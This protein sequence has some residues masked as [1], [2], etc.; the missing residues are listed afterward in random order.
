MDLG[1]KDKIALV[2]GSSSGVGIEIA[3]T[4]AREGANVAVHYN[5]SAEAA[6]ETVRRVKELGVDAKA[7]QADVSDPEQVKGLFKEVLDYFG[8]VDILVNN[9]ATVIVGPT[10]SF[11]DKKY[12]I[13]MGSQ[14]D[15]TFFCTREALKIM[16]EKRSGKVINI[17]SVAGIGAIPESAAYAAAKAGVIGLTRAVAK[18]MAPY[19]IQVNAVAPGYIETP[20]V[21]KLSKTEVGQKIFDTRQVPLGRLAK[22]SEIAAVVVFLASSHADYCVGE[23]FPV[24]GGLMTTTNLQVGD[25]SGN[26]AK[27]K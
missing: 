24:S 11:P 5:S 1:L 8:T 10:L 2:T 3:L 22:M 14:L 6:A 26:K 27:E 12:R 15:G 23:V 20:L 7:F 13:T 17:S 18:E 25:E 4:F 19:G 9:A 16:V 21:A